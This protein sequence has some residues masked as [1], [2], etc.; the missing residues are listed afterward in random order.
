MARLVVEPDAFVDSGRI[1]AEWVAELDAAG[2]ATGRELCDTAGMAGADATGRDFATAYDDASAAVLEGLARTA[3]GLARLA[4]AQ[5]LCGALYAATEAANSGLEAP[6]A[7]RPEARPALCPPLPPSA[8]GAASLGG[9]GPHQWVLD[10]CGIVW[11]GAEPAGL[12]AASDIWARAARRVGALAGAYPPDAIRRLSGCVSADATLVVDALRIGADDVH[13]LSEVCRALAESCSEFAAYVDAAHEEVRNEAFQVALETAAL[14]GVSAA[15]APLT[16]GGS[17]AVGVALSA[18]RATVVG[19]R[20]GATVNRLA[21]LGQAVAGRIAPLAE[22]CRA[23][24]APT[25][26]LT[27]GVAAGGAARLRA[28]AGSPR[29]DAAVRG[30]GRLTE[31]RAAKALALTR[32]VASGGVAGTLAG[33][34]GERAGVGAAALLGKGVAAGGRRPGM[35]ADWAAAL[36]DPVIR[37]AARRGAILA[38]SAAKLGPSVLAIKAAAH[39][40]DSTMG[41]ALP[42]RG[43]AAGTASQRADANAALATRLGA[44]RSA[45]GGTAGPRRP[46][47]GRRTQS[48]ERER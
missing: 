25:G 17:V 14:A 8:A 27:G 5:F 7:V 15:A 11:P 37:A 24:L 21:V 16:F 22:R 40:A 36:R 10:L 38:P 9:A 26:R 32:D 18:G 29:V 43:Y 6:P 31:T 46:R 13:T 48:V 42:G 30:I 28:M 20:L 44:A 12:R 33:H 19:I 39:A 2:A 34:L 1:T 4:D 47:A 41:A 23:L 45:A 3:G 35:R